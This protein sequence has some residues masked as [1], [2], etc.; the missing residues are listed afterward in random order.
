MRNNVTPI[1]QKAI[2]SSMKLPNFV[3]IRV[4][5][6]YSCRVDNTW[7]GKH[8]MRGLVPSSEALVLTSN[9]YLGI[10]QHSK[11]KLAIVQSVE[12]SGNGLLMSGIFLHGECPQL[13]LEEKFARYMRSEASVLCQSGYSAN[14]GLLQSIANAQ[15]PVYVDMMAHMSLWE[16]VKNAGAKPIS[17]IHNDVD[18]LE[19]QILRHGTGIVLV[20]SIYST[21][22]SM[23]P[24]VEIANICEK[25]DC[26][27]VVDESHALGTHGPQGEG[28]VVALGIENKV[29]FRTASLAKAFA[30]RA[31]LITCSSRFHEY[32]KFESYNA[33]F[34]STLLP[35]EVMGLGA[36]LEVIKE[37]GWRRKQLAKSSAFVRKELTQL[38][39]YLNRSQSQ[40][41]SLESGTEE[42]TIVLRDALERQGVFG[43]VFCAPA[44]AKNRSLIRLSLNANLENKDLNKLVEACAS[45]RD[46]VGMLN[47]PSTR[48]GK[49][50]DELTQSEYMVSQEK[51]A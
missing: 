39:Y 45:I 46:Q 34:S 48:R 3:N 25:L 38:G 20:D 6:Y 14:V 15:T 29:Q 11:I 51:I 33:I 21:S 44:T 41:I 42:Q 7:G 36:T 37:E 1:N 12:R 26:V 8:I 23:S 49:R 18:H 32:F 22:G 9:D 5:K 19:R 24:L 30:G 28:L 16:G 47:W 13:K 43:S 50:R 40:I 4:E 35:Y 2:F 10:S 17:F 27:L 31:G